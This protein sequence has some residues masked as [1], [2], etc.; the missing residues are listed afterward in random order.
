MKIVVTGA[1]GRL[2]WPL[3]QHL[4]TG[5]NAGRYEVVGTDHIDPPDGWPADVAYEEADLRDDRAMRQICRGAQAVVHLGAIS[6]RHPKM[7]ATE[8]YAINVQGTFNVLQAARRGGA[9]SVVVASSICA[10]GLPDALD[11]HGLE[12]LPI[13]EAHPCRPR[14]TY[15]LSKRVNEVSAETFARLTGISTICIR[16][17]MILN[18]L[19]QREW[20]ARALSAETPYLV[21]AD[22]IDLRD[23]ITVVET[24][25]ERTD[26]PFDIIGV[27]AETLCTK[28]P[29]GEYLRRFEP[30]VPWRGEAPGE[31]TPLIT[32]EKARRVLGFQ[33]KHTWQQEFGPTGP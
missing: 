12:Y 31:T 33:P 11:K 3:V 32:T 6:G 1:A 30:A 17:P 14:H 20:L 19:T 27:H 26:I 2:G 16:F 28:I 13:D 22:Y 18:F 4:L 15:D 24:C 23:A 9:R 10:I 25:L 7:L 5:A 8:L 21:L 29:T